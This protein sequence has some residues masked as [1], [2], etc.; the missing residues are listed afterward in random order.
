MVV[1]DSP[2]PSPA[3]G[4]PALSPA[5]MDRARHAARAPVWAPVQSTAAAPHATAAARAAPGDSMVASYLASAPPGL[6]EPRAAPGL[7][8][9]PPPVFV[10]WGDARYVRVADD[11]PGLASS[12]DIGALPSVHMLPP[13]RPQNIQVPRTP[14]RR[15]SR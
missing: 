10:Q 2:L 13:G 11:F 3:R 8:G 15:R 4:G 5:S 9:L 7:G 6:H 14:S 12:G 1:S